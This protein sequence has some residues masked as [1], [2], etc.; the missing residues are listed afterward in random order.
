MHPI[1]RRRLLSIMMIVLSVAIAMALALYALRQNINL[2]V[3]P[4]EIAINHFH[5]GQHFRLGGLVK[6][7]SVQ[8]RKKQLLVAFTLTD[9]SE[10][11]IVYYRGIL[12]DLFREG[13]GIVAEGHLNKDGIFIA[14]R[15]F[16]KHDE[17]YRPPGKA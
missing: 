8:Y 1:R 17:N 11:Q 4:K 16:A 15:V 9:Y 7:H 5:F 12:P 2:Y 10:E 6:Q 14:D 3:T 13:Q